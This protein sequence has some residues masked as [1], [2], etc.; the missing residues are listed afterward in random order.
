MLPT[1]C[2]TPH[3]KY[4]KVT[5]PNPR[6]M[7]APLSTRIHNANSQTGKAAREVLQ[8]RRR[9][10][11]PPPCLSKTSS[12]PEATQRGT[13]AAAFQ[14]TFTQLFT[15]PSVLHV[16]TKPRFKL[17]LFATGTNPLMAAG[18]LRAGFRMG[19]KAGGSKGLRPWKRPGGKGWRTLLSAGA[20][21]PLP[22]AQHRSPSP[23]A[24]GWDNQSSS[25]NC[26]LQRRTRHG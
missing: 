25:S 10:P 21:R 12:T 26:K 19:Y 6:R 4:V 7:D 16:K 2:I 8:R 23:P 5:F 15:I 18:T 17:S 20:H 13:L 14:P 22:S 11:P 9:F 24:P 3:C 1:P